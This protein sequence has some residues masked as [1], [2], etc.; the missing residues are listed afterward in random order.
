MLAFKRDAN[1][2]RSVTEIF[3]RLYTLLG[4]ETF[5]NLFRLC[6]TDCGSEFS[7]P[8]ALEFDNGGE[9]RTRIFYTKPGAPYQK[10]ACENNHSLIR[11][12]I[13]KG[14]SLKAYSQA[15]FDLLMNHINSYTRKKL[16]NRSPF[17]T[18]SFLHDPLIL[19][20]L[21]VIFINPDDV[22]LKPS[23]LKK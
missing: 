16:N 18:F 19:E 9:R 17:E 7:N 13:A 8:S 21:G 23:L 11:R 4:K 5:Q 1:T 22:T 10:G 3:D 20:K 14:T 2:A 6:L 15:D 12:V